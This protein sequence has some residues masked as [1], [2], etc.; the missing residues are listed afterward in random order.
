[1]VSI[2]P[3]DMAAFAVHPVLDRLPEL[4]PIEVEGAH[5]G[6]AIGAS[7]QGYNPGRAVVL[8][9]GLPDSVPGATVNR[10]GASIVERLRGRWR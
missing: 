3:D 6:A 10:M 5:V 9:A 1:M 8:L 4:D 7:D 2:R